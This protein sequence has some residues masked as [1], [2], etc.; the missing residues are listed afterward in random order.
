MP[1]F[2]Y[3]AADHAGKKVDGVMDAPDARAVVERLHRDA[4]YPIRVA[5]QA[6]RTAWCQ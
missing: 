6:E 4:Y 2:S 1:V 5:P 3:T